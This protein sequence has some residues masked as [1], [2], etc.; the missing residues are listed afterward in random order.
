MA[1]VT[2]VM[3]A[4]VF[5]AA[6]GAVLASAVCVAVERGVRAFLTDTRRSQCVCG[7][8]L[9]AWENVPV[10]GWVRCRGVAACCGAQIPVWY[11]RT[12]WYGLV[13]GALAGAVW[14]LIV[15]SGTGPVAAVVAALDAVG[16]CVLVTG[17]VAHRGRDR[18]GR[19]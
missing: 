15:T 6:I 3:L 17:E 18:V 14:A 1:Q 2:G 7:R 19:A 11:V 12:E 16:V 10:L 8:V 9:R 4:A 13:T 5:G